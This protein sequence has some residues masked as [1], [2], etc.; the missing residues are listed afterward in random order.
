MR[1]KRERI[2]VCAVAAFLLM[3]CAARQGSTPVSPVQQ[4]VT[5]PA[6]QAQAG[7]LRHLALGDSYTIGQ[8]VS[9][10]ERWPVQLARRLREEGIHLAD[11]QIIARTG[12]TTDELSRAMDQADIQG[13]YHLVTLLIGVNNQYRGRPGEEYRAQFAALVQRAVALAADKPS[14]VI[15]LSIP[16]WSVTPF[17]AGEDRVRIAA[18]IARFNALNREEATRAGARYVDITPL[19]REA[20]QDPSLLTSD[21]L[22]P[23]G[24]M[25]QGWTELVLPEA[26][27]ALKSL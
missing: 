27:A 25:Y 1:W 21:E 15:V 8:N 4:G 12:W 11:P 20:Q 3:A 24:K 9:L 22:H 7:E 18:E 5:A 13:P 2:T 6:A 26:R 16:D 14:R 19:S 10:S 23:S 17:A